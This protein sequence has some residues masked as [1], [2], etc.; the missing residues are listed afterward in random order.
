MRALSGARVVVTG[1][2][3][4]VGSHIVDAAIAA[5]A[6]EVI[7]LDALVR[8]VPENLADALRTGKARLVELDIRDRE[9]VRAN[10]AGADFVF[11]QAALRWTRC[12]ELPRECQEVMVDGTFNVLEAAADAKCKRVVLASSAVVYGEPERLPIDEDQPLA[13]TT[14]YG[15]A[16][17]ANEQMARAFAHLRDLPTTTLRYFNVY[18]PRMDVRS[19]YV[20]VMVRWL[21]LIDEGKPLTLFGDGTSSVDFVYIGD[22]ARANLLACDA[23]PT[24]AIVNVCSGVETRMRDLAA[25]LLE[26]TGSTV[27]IEYKPQPAGALPARRVGDPTRAERV[28]GF[29]AQTALADG[30]RRLI[31]WRRETLAAPAGR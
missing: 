6:R 1:G 21:N 11:H 30:V 15:A 18:G 14:V 9:A 12:Q 3:G 31:A 2:A 17:V 10:I 7:A 24:D 29:R 16:K 28:L 23:K 26:I 4:N 27:G 8:G 19:Q 13:G 25:L 22:V 5:G 20:E